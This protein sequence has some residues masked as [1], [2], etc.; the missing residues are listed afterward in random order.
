MPGGDIFKRIV[1]TLLAAAFL[2]HGFVAAQGLIICEDADG[3]RRIETVAM[4]SACHAEQ[5]D[6]AEP[7]PAE[8]SVPACTDTY[9]ASSTTAWYSAGQSGLRFNPAPLPLPVFRLTL[10]ARS[11]PKD[12]KPPETPD[13]HTPASRQH[14]L[15]I[16]AVVL[17]I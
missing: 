17:L 16:S 8:L 7:A 15:L 3:A 1:A 13:L 6:G 12:I 14:A 2:L 4:Q 5:V 10:M 11:E 9:F